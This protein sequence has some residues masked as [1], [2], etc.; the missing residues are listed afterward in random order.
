MIKNIIIGVLSVVVT[1]YIVLEFFP[2]LKNIKVH[3][4][5]DNVASQ[6]KVIG[7]V[8][9]ENCESLIS[10]G[11]SYDWI[12]EN[13]YA[14][15]S[16]EYKAY[17]KVVRAEKK[18]EE[19]QRKIKQKELAEKEKI[20]K[21]KA[22]NRQK[23]LNRQNQQQLRYNSVKG[24]CEREG[25]N[26][27]MYGGGSSSGPLTYFSRSQQAFDKCMERNRCFSPGNCN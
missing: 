10:V 5:F 16:D 24:H 27:G 22:E 3:I 15:N 19:I 6:K 17:Q 18:Y 4:E 25:I 11:G 21:Q 9:H 14:P 8:P 12:H 2:Q 26:K 7:F 1:G 13:C 23:Q 20:K